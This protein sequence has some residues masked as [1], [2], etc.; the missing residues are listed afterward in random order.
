MGR[1][2]PR[3]SF[4]DNETEEDIFRIAEDAHD[5]VDRLVVIGRN[6]TTNKTERVNLLSERLQEKIDIPTRPDAP[7][8]PVASTVFDS[9]EAAYRKFRDEGLF[10]RA[11][12]AQATRPR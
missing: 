7:G 6:P 8:L 12:Q 9:L 1:R 10:E 3:N 4:L 11:I 5:T 2:G